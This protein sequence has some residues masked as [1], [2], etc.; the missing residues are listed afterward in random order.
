MRFVPGCDGAVPVACQQQASLPAAL[1]AAR[2][3]AATVVVLVPVGHRADGSLEQILRQ[4]ETVEQGPSALD[5][6]TSAGR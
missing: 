2:R 3:A 6:G 5:V 4:L 1:A